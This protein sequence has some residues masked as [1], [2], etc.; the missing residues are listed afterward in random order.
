M[1]RQPNKLPYGIAPSG[2][3]LPNTTR[4]GRVRLQVADLDRSVTFYEQVLGFRILTQSEKSVS[5]GPVASSS[6]SFTPGNSPSLPLLELYEH[7]GARK[8]PRHGLLGLYH[9]AI[10]LPHR[11]HLGQF[12]RHLGEIGIH[13]GMADHWV[14]EAV[15]LSDPDGLGIEVYADRPKESWRHHERELSMTTLPLN[16]QEVLEAAQGQLWNGLPAETVI[17]HVHLHVGDLHAAESFYHQALGFDKTVW[18]YPGA[19]FLSAGGYHHHLGINIWAGNVPSAGDDDARLLD[20]EIVLPGMTNVEAVRDNLVK[21]Q[22][23]TAQ[24]E[25]EIITQDPWGTKVRITSAS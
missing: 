18:S 14:S 16:V 19:L 12:I 17:G 23:Q 5:L 25:G 11:L 10:L 15:Y 21:M 3:R 13:A 8:V 7:T 20:W 4:L 22:Y 24:K 6:N 9:F 2:Y 1:D